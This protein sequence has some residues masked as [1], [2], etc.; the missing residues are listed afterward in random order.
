MYHP[1]AGKLEIHCFNASGL[2]GVD[3]NRLSDP[4]VKIK[5]WRTMDSPKSGKKKTAP[6]W[7]FQTQIIWE[8]L[9]PVWNEVFIVEDV[10]EADLK[11]MS[12]QMVVH[13][14][15]RV[16][17]KSRALAQIRIG[18]D[19]AYDKFHWEEMMAN[20]GEL[21]KMTHALNQI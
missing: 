12:V 4:F 14:A 5:L 17:G 11:K 3:W 9:A 16:P 2:Q 8:T 18:P 6:T 20:P 15:S 21:I 7:K 19:M 13:D 10:M 1:V